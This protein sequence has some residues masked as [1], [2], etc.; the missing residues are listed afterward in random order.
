MSSSDVESKHVRYAF[1]H[2]LHMSSYFFISTHAS[3]GAR[4]SLHLQKNVLE[5]NYW[6]SLFM[7]LKNMYVHLS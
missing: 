7:G 4:T 5:D 6:D 3:N 1:L 2:R